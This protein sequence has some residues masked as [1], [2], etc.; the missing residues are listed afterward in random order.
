MTVVTTRP[1]ATVANGSST[2]TGAASRHAALNDDSDSSYVTLP[3][4]A[5]GA[6]NF[7]G[8]MAIVGEEGPELVNL[9]RGSDVIP[10]PQTAKLANG[11]RGIDGAVPDVNLYIEGDASALDYRIVKITRGE[12]TEHDHRGTQALRAGLV[13]A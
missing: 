13:R 7:A 11:L 10:A 12:I 9:P 6:T 8:G 5:S 3:A 1:D 2:V 4:L